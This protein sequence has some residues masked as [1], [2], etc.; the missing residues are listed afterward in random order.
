MYVLESPH[1]LG[2]EYE[3]AMETAQDLANP[4]SGD[5]SI[6]F[7]NQDAMRFSQATERVYHNKGCQGVLLTTKFTV[8]LIKNS[9]QLFENCHYTPAFCVLRLVFK[10]S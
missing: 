6:W 4:H 10:R 8:F 2:F 7:W 3:I 1:P 5:L 9:D